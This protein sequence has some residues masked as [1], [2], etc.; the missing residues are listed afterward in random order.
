METLKND[1]IEQC[2][3]TAKLNLEICNDF[4]YVDGESRNKGEG[5]LTKDSVI[6]CE[7]IRTV[8]K[9]RITRKLVIV[10]KK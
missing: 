2:K 9:R 7:K 8:D 3:D 10:Y 1:L 5:G 6:Q 4:K